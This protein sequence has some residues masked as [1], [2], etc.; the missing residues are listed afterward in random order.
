M[1]YVMIVFFPRSSVQHLILQYNA[2]VH[3]DAMRCAKTL[4][5]I[6]QKFEITAATTTM[7]DFFGSFVAIRSSLWMLVTCGSVKNWPFG[8]VLTR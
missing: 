5:F 3:T 1:S 4:V 7:S 6:L 2:F 8:F